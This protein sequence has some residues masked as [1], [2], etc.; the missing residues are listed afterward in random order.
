MWVNVCTV[1]SSRYVCRRRDIEKHTQSS[2]LHAH[3]LCF[4]FFDLMLLSSNYCQ[5]CLPT[6]TARAKSLSLLIY[7]FNSRGRLHTFAA[8]LV[9][10]AQQHQ[11]DSEWPVS[12]G[13]SGDCPFVCGGTRN[14]V[15]W[16]SSLSLYFHKE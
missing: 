6:C 5:V 9:F 2:S 16:H 7:L 15:I 8:L 12:S 1:A 13:E 10:L 4:F 3:S 11:Q 14:K